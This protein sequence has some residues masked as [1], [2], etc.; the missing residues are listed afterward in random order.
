MALEIEIQSD[1]RQAQADLNKLNKSVEKIS[2]SAERTGNQLSSTFRVIGVATTA[3]I[4]AAGLK[5]VTDSFTRINNQIALTTG[6]TNALIATQSKLLNVSRRVNSTLEQ[7]VTLYSSLARNTKLSNEEAVKLAEVL[8]KAGKIGGGSAQTINSSLIQL[9]QGLAAGALRGQ[10]LNSVLEG[11]PR[12]A[13]AIAKSLGEDVGALRSLA[14]EGKL[15]AKVVERA[16]LGSADAIDKE[17]SQLRTTIS[18]AF[19]G[20]GRDI[21]VG[22]NS[23]FRVLNTGSLGRTISQLGAFVGDTL[24]GLSVSFRAFQTDLL[25]FR[26]RVKSA[27][28][29]IEDVPGAVLSKMASGVTAFSSKLKEAVSLVS[30]ILGGIKDAFYDVYMYVI[31]NS[32]Y[33]DMVREVVAYT[34]NLDGV[35]KFLGKF[36]STIKEIFY[37]IFMYVVGNSVWK[38]MILLIIKWAGKL[39]PAIDSLAAFAS[40]VK[41]IFFALGDSVGKIFSSLKSGIMDFGRGA[42]Q[43]FKN[44][45]NT[46]AKW[47]SKL[48]EDIDFLVK[49]WPVLGSFME[50]KYGNQIRA[51]IDQVAGASLDFISKWGGLIVTALGTA[52]YATATGIGGAIAGGIIA[53]LGAYFIGFSK[54]FDTDD[55]GKLDDRGKRI[56]TLTTE[57]QKQTNFLQKISDGI[58]VVIA[59]PIDATAGILGGDKYG[60]AKIGT[61]IGENL[62]AVVTTGFLSKNLLASGGS[63]IKNFFQPEAGTGVAGLAAARGVLSASDFTDMRKE[64]NILND[65]IAGASEALKQ[66]KIQLD[67][68]NLTQQEYDKSVANTN[69]E[70]LRNQERRFVLNKEIDRTG[71][72]YQNAN[73]KIADAA[74]KTASSLGTMFGSIGGILGGFGGAALGSMLSTKWG[75]SAGEQFVVTIALAKLGE[76][77]A[78]AFLGYVGGFLGAVLGRAVAIGMSGA[79]FKTMAAA[80]VAAFVKARTVFAAHMLASAAASALRY[81]MITGAGLRK[82]SIKSALLWVTTVSSA[83]IV[84]STKAAFVF[85][86]GLITAAV[87]GSTLMMTALA[88]GLSLAIYAA[89]NSSAVKEFGSNIGKSIYETIGDIREWHVL[90][91]EFARS[92]WE[93]LTS[94]INDFARDI[95]QTIFSYLGDVREWDD[96]A[97][98]FVKTMWDNLKTA[99]VELGTSLADSFINVIENFS[100]SD[101]FSSLGAK[102]TFGPQSDERTPQFFNQG[103]SVS[104]AG[105]GTSDSIPAMLSNGEFVIKESVAK[106]NRGLLETLNS[107][108]ALPSFS[109]GGF[110]KDITDFVVSMKDS[111]FKRPTR[112]TDQT[113]SLFRGDS[114][115][116]ESPYMKSNRFSEMMDVAKNANELDHLFENPL[117]PQQEF[118]DRSRTAP[119]MAEA[120][121]HIADEEGFVDRVYHD[122]RKLLTIG[123]GHLLTA[124]EAKSTGLKLSKEKL[125][126]RA[127][128]EPNSHPNDSF[129]EQKNI[130]LPGLDLDA[131]YEKDFAKHHKIAKAT[132]GEKWESFTKPMK[133]ALTDHAFQLGSFTGWPGLVG[134]I[135]SG[136]MPDYDA[137]KRNYASSLN[138]T[139]TPNR[140]DRRIGLI[141]QAK[142]IRKF[143]TGGSVFGEGTATSDSI[144][145][146]LSN[147]EFVVKASVANKN[148]SMLE[149]LNN[150]SGTISKFSEGGSVGASSLDQGVSREQ[151]LLAK[152]ISAITEMLKQTLGEENFAAI[153]NAVTNIKDMFS[154]VFSSF[155][156]APEKKEQFFDTTELA[157]A[158]KTAVE[159]IGEGATVDVSS[160]ST[161]LDKNGKELGRVI[162]LTKAANKINKEILDSGDKV[163]LELKAQQLAIADD[164]MAI[165]GEQLIV[166]TESL[167]VSKQISKFA[168]ATGEA[169][170]TNVKNDFQGGL[171]GLLKGE[172]SFGDFG[173]GLLDS[174]SSNVIDSFSSG[175]TEGLFSDKATEDGEGTKP[176]LQSMFSKLFGDVTDTGEGIGDVAGAAISNGLTPSTPLFVK[177]VEATDT[178]GLSG[179]LDIPPLLENDETPEIKVDGDGLE[180]EEEGEKAAGAFGG[181]FQNFT[182][183]F[184]D[185]MGGITSKFSG[186][187]GGVMSSLSG[188]L[189]GSGGAG[190]LLSAVGGL[191]FHSGG[192][193]PDGGGYSKLNGGEM[194]LTEAQQGE[195]FRQAKGGKG[196]EQNTVTNNIQIT[197]D[198]SRQTKKEIYAMMPQIASGVN[199]NNRENSR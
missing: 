118:Y 55:L 83:L 44:V 70:L 144:P 166:A 148:R 106:K 53:V 102:D 177:M 132:F 64:L 193:V 32:I 12:I 191:F 72:I 127:A 172:L 90:A 47:F 178:S 114:N 45:G 181:V 62:L 61:F 151:D 119:Y 66:N 182:G 14:E 6:R 60:L 48:K 21:G 27:F 135:T 43:V 117:W 42:I 153:D 187:F 15:T 137:M 124:K 67:R 185:L 149:S 120:R 129:L 74:S 180:I 9:Q 157:S 199:Q 37:N 156:A 138:Y 40:N 13:Q 19:L 154:E 20:A 170:A 2:N 168:K 73:S 10:E 69:K 29:D 52:L 142:K 123:G 160:L 95:G 84:A 26:L 141:E 99:T 25:I 107:T 126:W 16:L 152:V 28:K 165:L 57:L 164:L 96:I 11:T 4:G 23:I 122:S 81:V 54:Q 91:I 34:S 82:N 92:L 71:A 78:G 186:L 77:I 176:G 155:T 179:G 8:I 112:I 86:T 159:N 94:G 97:I 100:W 104:G 36:A 133:I 46:G 76:M 198:I 113:K 18:E 56:T 162:T 130:S 88:A 175:I 167:E 143:S 190:G 196:K 121:K 136:D 5:G 58:G 146:M 163:P 131:L 63:A 150:S 192:L 108:G 194:V 183:K 22:L 24:V 38:D 184:G 79:I 109:A 125:G 89:F 158:V 31:G 80:V 1:S 128:N 147:G 50:V 98:R 30:N 139:Q 75:M 116:V 65:D 33:K 115:F 173:S 174:F 49:I 51:L 189:G 140:V 197:G 195:L 171:S 39:K 3:L 7:T 87:A 68:G 35:F 105:T 188:L 169:A 161:F 85:A 59:A 93:S 111:L 17:F 103:G 134:E 110:V 41:D 101:L 145:A